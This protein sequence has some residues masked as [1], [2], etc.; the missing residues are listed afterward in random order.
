MEGPLRTEFD[1][2]MASVEATLVA[3]GPRKAAECQ[4]ALLHT[5]EQLLQESAGRASGAT[6]TSRSCNELACG[7]SVL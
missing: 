4:A 6:A 3:A 7:V 5:I 2:A 1:G